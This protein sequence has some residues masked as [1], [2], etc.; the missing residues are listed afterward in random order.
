MHEGE[1]KLSPSCI[2]TQKKMVLPKY[3][4]LTSLRTFPGL[5]YEGDL[6][7]SWLAGHILGR[8]Y[9]ILNI[10]GLNWIQLD[11]VGSFLSE[12]ILSFNKITP[13][14]P[15]SSSPRSEVFLA[16]IFDCY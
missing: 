2:C 16:E 15:D 8:F 3:G 6:I 5:P 9:R 4:S 13:F 1:K 10:I 7:S 11:T 14:F 12:F